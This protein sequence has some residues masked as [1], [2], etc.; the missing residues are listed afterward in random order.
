LQARE[1][2]VELDLP[3]IQQDLF[4]NAAADTTATQQF[5]TPPPV[6][7]QSNATLHSIKSSAAPTI[8]LPPPPSNAPPSATIVLPVQG[9]RDLHSLDLGI[10]KVSNDLICM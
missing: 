8:Q 10:V 2:G 9:G 7:M 3:D 1:I 4:T 5:S 6:C